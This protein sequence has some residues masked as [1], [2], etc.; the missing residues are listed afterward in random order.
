MTSS[1]QN[2]ELN[3]LITGHN[4]FAFDFYHEVTSDE[5]ANLIFSPFSIEQAFGMLMGAARDNT[6]AQIAAT[7]HYTLPQNTLH[8][9]FA[10]LNTDLA[11]REA[12]GGGE[13]ERLQL[14]IAN[15]IW[16]QDGFPFRPTYTDLLQTY[17]GGGLR[18]MDFA[19]EPENARQTINEWI[20]QETEDKIRDMLPPGAVDQLTRMVLVNA[21]YFNGSWLYPFAD[22]GTQDQPF[23]LLDG[24]TVTVP[25]MMQQESLGYGQGEGFQVVELPY[26]GGD[27]AMLIVLPDA[28]QFDAIQAQLDSAFFDMARSTL[29][30]RPVL[31]HMPRFEFESELSLNVI[32]QGLGMTDVFDPNAANL[33]GMFDPAATDENLFVTAALHKAYIGVDEAGTEAAAATAIMVGTTSL[34]P[35]PVEVQL[36]RP[37]VYTIYDRQTGVILFLG[38]VMNP[39]E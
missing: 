25:M 12:A 3:I 15:S 18:F 10:A 22:R 2:D 13:G 11:D 21:I 5:D 32:L 27:M 31:L 17:Y 36:D 34:P 39:A 29:G 23:T 6:E 30:Y 4:T 24:S 8:P 33:T 7:M 26:F 19:A 28:G 38:Q 16:A 9:A 37:F 14:N 35:A 20:E 1:A